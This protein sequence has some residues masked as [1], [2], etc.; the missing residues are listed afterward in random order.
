[1]GDGE[2]TVDWQ[3]SDIVFD[4]VYVHGNPVSVQH[5]LILN[6]RSNAIVDSYVSDIHWVGVE[7]HAIA[8][9]AG[10]GPFKIV[11]N[12]LDG[13]GAN[14]MFG[15]ADPVI[16]GLSPSDIEIRGNYLF[17]P[18]SYKGMGY[19]VKNLL[20]LKHAKRVLI[21]GNVME[22]SWGDAQIGWAVIFQSATDPPD[23]APQTQT[24]DVTMRYNVIKNVW[25]GA[26]LTANG[27]N[28]S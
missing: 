13:A 6:G 3:P 16:A 22:N 28:G 2:G 24:A 9:W 12:F 20:E 15:G 18:L 8:S 14:I 27:Y 1:V 23:L 7:S 19:A 4:R 11:N 25:G 21:E 17:K 26:D 10:A 5:A